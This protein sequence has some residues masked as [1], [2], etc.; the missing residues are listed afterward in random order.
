[1]LKNKK[2]AL[3]FA[4]ASIL[5][6]L[7]LL[8]NVSGQTSNINWNIQTVDDKTGG[9]L[10]STG[11]ASLALDSSGNPHMSYSDHLDGLKYA[12]WSGSN[13]NIET[14]CSGGSSTS[15]SLALDSQGNPHI[16]FS[17]SINGFNSLCYAS[18]NGS[19][20]KIEVVNPNIG[21]HESCPSL[22]LDSAGKPHISYSDYLDESGS[23]MNYA[24]WDG[25]KWNLQTLEQTGAVGYSSLFLD[26]LGKPHIGYNYNSFKLRYA[27]LVGSDWQIQTVDDA[28][29]IKL[30]SSSLFLDF[31]GNPHL[32]YIKGVGIG[33]SGYDLK[34]GSLNG[35]GWT[36]HEIDHFGNLWGDCSLVLDLGGKPHI[37]YNVG[38]NDVGVL[39]Y[40]VWDSSKW[41]IQTVEESKHALYSALALDSNNNPHICITNTAYL[42][43]GTWLGELEY[44][45]ITAPSDTT[46]YQSNNS[47]LIWS[48]VGLAIIVVV[49][50]SIAVYSFKHKK[51]VKAK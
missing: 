10:E 36:I 13:W 34:Y 21:L 49:A 3:A 51:P 14:V 48:T 42:G 38:D 17:Q 18:W 32:C 2:R 35:S 28:D 40:A 44:A 37:S 46:A 22:A 19:N 24:S 29:Y 12:S 11:K 39:K 4:V 31:N 30:S 41:N 15:S 45:S 1:M 5:I 8:G 16:S 27:S 9:G 50:A 6:T 43:H 47:I 26:S 25:S 7:T 20:W 23:H 33:E